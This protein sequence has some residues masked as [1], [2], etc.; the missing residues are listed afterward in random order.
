M[1]EN[2]QIGSMYYI[3]DGSEL[4][5]VEVKE[6]KGGV[7]RAYSTTNRGFMLEKSELFKTIDDVF[8]FCNCIIEMRKG[9]KK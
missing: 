3:L 5:C 8:D 6:I 1:V 7:Y 4:L 2:P 9:L